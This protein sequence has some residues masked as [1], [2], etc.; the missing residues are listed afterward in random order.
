LKKEQLIKL[1][2]KYSNNNCTEAEKEV[3]ELFF[4]KL[5]KKGKDLPIDLSEEKRDELFLKITAEIN[6][7]NFRFR[8]LVYKIS[9]IAAVALF[10]IGIPLATIFYGNEK[11][12]TVNHLTAKSEIKNILLPEGSQVILNANS[13]ISY[14]EDFKQNRKLKL[15]GEAFFKVVKNPKS[16]FVVETSQFKTKVLGTSFNVKAYP[17]TINTVSVVTGKVEVNSKENLAWKSILIKNQWISIKKQE[18][19]QL[20]NDDAKDFN[21]WTKNILIFQ[22]SSLRE[23]AITLE[24]QFNVTIV[25]E[26]QELE[27]LRITGKFKEENLNN[28]LNSIALVKQLEIQF[29]TKNKIYVRKKQSI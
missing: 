28:I 9:K 19:P 5:Q 15:I 13:S 29:L 2:D 12:E 3:V 26:K 24:N 10:F 16:P 17:N 23:T 6:K 4:Q 14:S 18:A 22:N 20:S 25:F 21:A 27:E 11:N 8:N 7:S 1:A